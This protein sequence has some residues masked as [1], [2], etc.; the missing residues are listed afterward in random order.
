MGQ[1]LCGMVS[2]RIIVVMLEVLFMKT[3]VSDDDYDGMRSLL[4]R[5]ERIDR[6]E[7]R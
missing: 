5:F 1:R 3:K 2:H 4:S 7:T 6:D